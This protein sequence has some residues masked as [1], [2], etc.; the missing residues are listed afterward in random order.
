[1]AMKL[2]KIVLSLIFSISTFALFGCSYSGLNTNNESL[3]EKGATYLGKN[4]TSEIINVDSS[5]SWTIKNKNKDDSN[6]S[7]VSV[8]K[9]GETVGKY[10]V[11]RL[12]A[13]EVNGDIKSAFAK[14]EGREFITVIDGNEVY[15]RSIADENRKSIKEKM[16]SSDD[17]DEYIKKISNYVFT[18]Q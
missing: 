13:T 6:Y 4:A 8:N 5:D 14:R 12:V 7:V 9:T 18:R 10:P 1:M 11:V 17:P 16:E 2:K 3:L 15:F